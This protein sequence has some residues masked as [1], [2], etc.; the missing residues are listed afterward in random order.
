MA[1]FPPHDSLGRQ[2]GN[3]GLADAGPA[4]KDARSSEYGAW[5]RATFAP[6]RAQQRE[7]LATQVRTH[8][9]TAREARLAGDAAAARTALQRASVARTTASQWMRHLR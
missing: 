1:T 9:D 8:L 4:P 5:H 7:Q 6:V 2:W 3:A